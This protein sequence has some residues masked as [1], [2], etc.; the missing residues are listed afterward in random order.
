MNADDQ[1]E[2][3][4]WLIDNQNSLRSST[5]DRASVI[6]T[7]DAFLLA[8]I[9]FLIERFP[10]NITQNSYEKLIFIICTSVTVVLLAF[11]ILYAVTAAGQSIWKKPFKAFQ[12]NDS[13]QLKFFALGARNSYFL[14]DKKERKF[15]DFSNAVSLFEEELKSSTPNQLIK[16]A[17]GTLLYGT[18]LHLSS[19][20]NLR[21]SMRFLFMAIIP[22][23][24]SILVFFVKF[25]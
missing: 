16:S 13:D 21:R 8:G 22:F 2:L 25:F 6:V 10:S 17:S 11:S 15:K 7:A 1:L 12:I 24:V 18:R 23:T 14:Y 3:I 20:N 4:K 19:W 9:T 5:S